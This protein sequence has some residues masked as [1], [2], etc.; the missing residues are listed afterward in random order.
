MKAQS[1]RRWWQRNERIIQTI[2]MVSVILFVIFALG[3]FFKTVNW[4]QVGNGLASLSPL[5][6][7]IMLILGCLAVTP[8]LGY[9]F[10]LVHLLKQ[11]DLYSTFYIVRSGW[12]T[13]TLTNIAGFGGLLGATLRAYFYGKKSTR[14]QILL[15][16]SKI[17]IFLLSGLSVLC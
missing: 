7:A 16:I 12:I 17:A 14:T 8:M 11:R 15:A 9:D 13:N 6:I 4:H 10:A 3:N 5:S 2:F 1:I